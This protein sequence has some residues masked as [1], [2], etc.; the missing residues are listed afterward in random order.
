MRPHVPELFSGEKTHSTGGQ[1]SQGLQR[2]HRAE[3][4]RRQEALF[5][6]TADIRYR[7]QRKETTLPNRD[8]KNKSCPRAK[9]KI[10]KTAGNSGRRKKRTRPGKGR[11]RP[12]HEDSFILRQTG[13]CIPVAY[14]PGKKE[15]PPMEG[16]YREKRE[17]PAAAYFPACGQYHRRRGA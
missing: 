5:R 12:S 2:P 4:E 3:K 1:E 16:T 7:Q 10:R 14:R 8:H 13:H 6:T 17:K 11:K 15:S 9:S